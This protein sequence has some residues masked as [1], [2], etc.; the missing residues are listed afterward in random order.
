MRLALS[1]NGRDCL[2]FKLNRTYH[3]CGFIRKRLRV[4]RVGV[5]PPSGTAQSVANFTSQR[6]FCCG[7][8]SKGAP[9]FVKKRTRLDIFFIGP[10]HCRGVYSKYPGCNQLGSNRQAERLRASQTSLR[11]GRFAVVAT[12]RVRLALSENGRDCFIFKL[13]RTYHA[14]GSIYSK[15]F[16]SNRL[17]SNRQAER[18]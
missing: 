12:R 7:R 4:Q 14:P 16:A 9:R 1:K 8:H 18:L 3:H 10:H 2:I 6:S 13:N 15:D 11:R 17:G 5:K